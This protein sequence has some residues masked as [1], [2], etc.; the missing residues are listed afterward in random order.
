MPCIYIIRVLKY[1]SLPKVYYVCPSGAF[2]KGLRKTTQPVMSVCPSI[3]TEQRD[4]LL[5]DFRNIS[6]LAVLLKYVLTFKFCLNTDKCTFL[7]S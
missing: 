1:A 2:S 7:V 6:Y 5:N 3:Y 4:S